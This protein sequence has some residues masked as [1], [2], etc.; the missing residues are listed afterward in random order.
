V[1]PGMDQSEYSCLKE[2]YQALK[3]FD[4]EKAQSINTEI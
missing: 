1:M 3:N 2:V 4:A